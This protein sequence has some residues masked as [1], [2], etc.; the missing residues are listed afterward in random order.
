MRD[1]GDGRSNWF[2]ATVAAVAGL[3]SLV[4]CSG[5]GVAIAF[6]LLLLG[7][8]VVW[9]GRLDLPLFLLGV[10][11]AVT[12]ALASLSVPAVA[13][14]ARGGHVTKTVVLSSL[15]FFAF[16]FLSIVSLGNEFAVSFALM[17]LVATPAVISL[18]A[19]QEKANT[20]L[21]VPRA[22]VLAAVA[23][24]CASLLA[25]WLVPTDDWPGV[26][27]P[28][29]MAASSWPVLPALVAALRSD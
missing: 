29:F 15:G 13:L 14:G 5:A 7:D 3:G 6:L 10:G 27:T 25:Y 17:G 2:R 21:R 22:A 19:I 11:T 23:I 12:L 8:Y 26:L 24:Y 18:V 16:V 1:R 28:V 4:V 20:A 9:L